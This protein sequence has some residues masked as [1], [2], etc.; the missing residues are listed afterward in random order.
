MYF[1]RH[2]FLPIEIPYGNR[3]YVISLTIKDFYLSLT[4]MGLNYY[5]VPEGGMSRNPVLHIR[6]HGVIHVSRL[7]REASSIII[8]Y[9]ISV[10]CVIYVIYNNRRNFKSFNFSL[11]MVIA[12]RRLDFT[13]FLVM[14]I[15]SAT[16]S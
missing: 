1:Y 6:S 16:S 11:K 14:D 3:K 7:R 4:A 5:V 12:S 8:R 2:T 13:V 9:K 10:F 15:F